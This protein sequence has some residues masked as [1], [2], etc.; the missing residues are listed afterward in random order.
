MQTFT[1]KGNCKYSCAVSIAVNIGISFIFAH[2][3]YSIPKGCRTTND[4]FKCKK[5]RHL[6]FKGQGPIQFNYNV[7]VFTHFNAM[8]IFQC[9]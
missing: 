8:V 1:A 2:Y 6:M 9:V 3:Y 7:L 5:E 4:K